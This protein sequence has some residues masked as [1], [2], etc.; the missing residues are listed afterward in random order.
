[1]LKWL[2]LK[3]NI[4]WAL[5]LLLLLLCR[6]IKHVYILLELRLAGLSATWREEGKKAGGKTHHIWKG[7]I[8]HTSN[9]AALICQSLFED[10]A[11]LYESSWVELKS[12]GVKLDSVETVTERRMRLKL[13]LPPPPSRPGPSSK[14]ADWKASKMQD[15][16][17]Q[18]L[19]PAS[20]NQTL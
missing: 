3:H 19:L 16:A 6:S 4:L 17:A 20:T 9:T 12:V 10:S 7:F 11:F 14:H 8:F 13:H 15:R 2:F 1:M 18:K 5:L